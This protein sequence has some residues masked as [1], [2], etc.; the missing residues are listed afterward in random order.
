MMMEKVKIVIVIHKAKKIKKMELTLTLVK[1]KKLKKST[2]M[3]FD[4][5]FCIYHAY[6]H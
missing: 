2:L 4:L 3:I 5:L 1:R 6:Y